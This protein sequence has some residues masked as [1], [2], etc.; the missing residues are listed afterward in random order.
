MV[1]KSGSST[2]KRL[3]YIEVRLLVQD[4]AEES[5]AAKDNTKHSKQNRGRHHTSDA[6]AIQ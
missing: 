3:A 1:L 2:R 6:T 5:E 4:A